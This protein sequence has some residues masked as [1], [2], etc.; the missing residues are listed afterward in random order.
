MMNFSASRILDTLIIY[1]QNWKN[2]LWS[3]HY[4]LLAKHKNTMDPKDYTDLCNIIASIIHKDKKAPEKTHTAKLK[5]DK[6]LG[7]SYE[8]FILCKDT[9][10][11]SPQAGLKV[12]KKRRKPRTKTK[13]KRPRLQ[14]EKHK[15]T[16]VKCVLPPKESIPME[17]LQK[18][19]INLS[20]KVLTRDHLYVFY[21][22]DSF[23]PTP[24]LPNLMK[25]NDDVI[26]WT[27]SLRRTVHFELTVKK[28]ENLAEKVESTP[29]Q[30]DV[31]SME[32]SLVKFKAEGPT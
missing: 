15:R 3:Q 8:S 1:Y 14:S 18:S 6:E 7:E 2:N 19:V 30:D 21:L 29:L 13:R 32:R 22:G 11:A 27:N 31:T 28:Q 26:K 12:R 9:A 17:T 25:F 5:R 24:K 10:K 20:S 16:Q 23:A 4:Q